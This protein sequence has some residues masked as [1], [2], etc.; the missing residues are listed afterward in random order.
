[1]VGSLVY[2]SSCTRPDLS[3]LITKLSEK[4]E[5]PTRAHFNACN[6]ALRYIKGTINKGL[7]FKPS[8]NENGIQLL[9]YSDSDWGSS[10]DRKSLS[11]YCFQLSGGNSFISWKCKKQQTIA[12]S[13]CEAEYI[14]ANFALQE[15]LF[16]RQLLLDMKYPKL[17]INLYVD[18]KGAIELGK[19]PVHHQRSKHIDIRYHFLREKVGDGSLNL[20]KISSQDNCADLFTKPAK[21]SNLKNFMM[22]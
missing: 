14:A 9:G 19:N 13:T 10:S 21:L 7:V 18:N 1:M 8:S 16:L 20:L 15:G 22:Y 12:L 11:G 6:F 4:L 3:Y 5:N 17:Q 2:L